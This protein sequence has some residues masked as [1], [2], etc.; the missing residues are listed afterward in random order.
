MSRSE[1][2]L[3]RLYVAIG[4]ARR[5]FQGIEPSGSDP[6][7]SLSEPK[8][9]GRLVEEEGNQL[10]DAA[11]QADQS[12]GGVPHSPRGIDARLK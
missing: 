7:K 6:M 11:G 8:Q 10:D 12:P 5:R 2:R 9:F 4:S 3:T 1:Q